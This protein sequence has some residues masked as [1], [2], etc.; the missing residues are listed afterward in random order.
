MFYDRFKAL[1]EN[2]KTTPT[3]AAID[4]GFSNSITTNGKRQGQRRTVLLLQKSLS[5][6]ASPQMSFWAKKNSPPKVSCLT[7]KRLCWICFVRLGTMLG[8]WHC[9]HQNTASKSDILR[10]LPHQFDETGLL[11][12]QFLHYSSPLCRLRTIPSRRSV[13]MSYLNHTPFICQN[14]LTVLWILFLFLRA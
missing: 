12:C 7:R 1:C 4:M 9:L 10:V 14:L 3:R 5:T 13:I 6:S 2:K 11:L 8:A